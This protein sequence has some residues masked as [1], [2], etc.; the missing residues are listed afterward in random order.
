MIIDWEY[1]HSDTPSPMLHD[2]VPSPYH[3]CCTCSTA[4]HMHTR[5]QACLSQPACVQAAPADAVCSPAC[6]AARAVPTPPPAS[7][8]AQNPSCQ[9]RVHTGSCVP[10]PASGGHTC[11]GLRFCLPAAPVGVSLSACMYVNDVIDPDPTSAAQARARPVTQPTAAACDTAA[12]VTAAAAA[13]ARPLLTARASVRTASRTRPASLTARVACPR[14]ALAHA[15]GWV[16]KK[17]AR[18]L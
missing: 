10:L 2:F 9:A 8:T 4:A 16:G 5:V 12:D 3:E 13:S 14:A 6:Q 15:V 17:Q 11:A 18:R 1:T 7:V